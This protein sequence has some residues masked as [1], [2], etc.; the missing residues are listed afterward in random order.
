MSVMSNQEDGPL[1]YNIGESV[2]VQCQETF[3]ILPATIKI[4]P[5]SRSQ[6]YTIELEDGS[7]ADVDKKISTPNIWYQHPGNLQRQWFSFVPIG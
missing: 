5:N 4:P 2:F 7:T 3:D 1:Q 6:F